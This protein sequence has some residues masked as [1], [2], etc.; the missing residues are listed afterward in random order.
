MPW[1]IYDKQ[2]KKSHQNPGVCSSNLS[3]AK[4][5][6]RLECM[7]GNEGNANKTC[8][9]YTVMILFSVKDNIGKTQKQNVYYNDVITAVTVPWYGEAMASCTYHLKS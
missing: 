3:L 6:I 7:P 1:L 2:Q 5:M 4:G 8:T 9:Y